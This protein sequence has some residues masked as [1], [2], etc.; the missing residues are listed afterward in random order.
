M[1]RHRR[2]HELHPPSLCYIC[3][4]G[5]ADVTSGITEP[6]ESG[7][8]CK[9]YDDVRP[10]ILKCLAFLQGIRMWQ[11]ESELKRRATLGPKLPSGSIHP[12]S[13]QPHVL[14]TL[15][16][17]GHSLDHLEGHESDLQDPLLPT[18][19]AYTVPVGLDDFPAYDSQGVRMRLSQGLRSSHLSNSPVLPPPLGMRWSRPLAGG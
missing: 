18:S 10:Y 11:A 6:W 14:S 3:P 7:W 12:F 9:W 15:P 4:S 16:D 17:H 13:R 8:R 19:A 1:Q 5:S 2:P